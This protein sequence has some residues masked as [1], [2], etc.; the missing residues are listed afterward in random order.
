MFKEFFLWPKNLKKTGVV[1]CSF[2]DWPEAIAFWWAR[3]VRLLASTRRN[4]VI[5][6]SALVNPDLLSHLLILSWCVFLSL[7]PRWIKLWKTRP[8]DILLNTGG[9]LDYIVFLRNFGALWINFRT[10]LKVSFSD[11]A[12]SYSLNKKEVIVNL[13]AFR[14][15]SSWG[16][17]SV[18]VKPQSSDI[19]K[20]S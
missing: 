14:R 8:I 20:L 6:D 11:N 7:W 15:L 16:R 17:G 18:D 13:C 12:Y 10:N 3:W 5:N 1:R 4:G 2:R 9:I 19:Q